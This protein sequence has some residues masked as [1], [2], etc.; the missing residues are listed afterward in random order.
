MNIANL[1]TLDYWFGQPFAAQGSSLWLLIGGFLLCIVAGL[2][3]KIASQF[4][5]EKFKKIILKR[6]GNLGTVMGFLGL[7]WMFFRQEGAV[8]LAWRFWL[9]LWLAGFF[10]RLSI[11]VRYMVK[12][13]PDIKQEEEKRVQIEKYLPKSN[14]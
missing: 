9:L 12:R 4:K 1:F 2:I 11:I 13:V 6:L 8:F 7:V 5:E 3:C 10:W 14:K